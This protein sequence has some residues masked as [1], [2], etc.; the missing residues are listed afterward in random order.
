[1]SPLRG[2][3]GFLQSGYNNTTPSG[4]ET[5]REP[6]RGEIIITCHNGVGMGCAYFI[7][8]GKYKA[9]WGKGRRMITHRIRASS[10]GT[11]PLNIVFN[12]TSRATPLTT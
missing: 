4:F 7:R 11:T 9:S 5:I 10:R 8:D 12:G 2:S 3:V 1:M 6:R